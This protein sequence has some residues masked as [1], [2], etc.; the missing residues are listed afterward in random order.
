M[1]ERVVLRGHAPGPPAPPESAR[2]VVVVDDHRTFADLLT[3]ALDAATDLK[4]VGVAYDLTTGLRLVT[5]NRPDLVVM[6]YEFAGE[7]RDGVMATGVIT[8]RFPECR[9][10]V[11]TGHADAVMLRRAAE[12]G[13][14]SLMPKDG[15]LPDLLE[16]LRTAGGDGLKVHPPLLRSLVTADG[17]QAVMD[18]PLSKREQEVLALLVLG[19][20]AQEV[21]DQLGISKNTS[22]GYIKSLLWKLDAHTQLEAVAIARRQGLVPVSDAR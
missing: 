19:L 7:Q 11:L 15:S 10:V 5:S 12:A 18:N 1:V 2:T 13:A 16:A 8:S 3:F 17:R 14:S 4:C 22:R 21:A 9:V 6:D 20:G